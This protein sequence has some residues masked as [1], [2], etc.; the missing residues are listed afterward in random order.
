M[1]LDKYYVKPVEESLEECLATYG[2]NFHLTSK[3][4]LKFFQENM[5]ELGDCVLVKVTYDVIETLLA[6]EGVTSK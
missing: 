4:A 3:E 1:V 5:H 6:G 2:D